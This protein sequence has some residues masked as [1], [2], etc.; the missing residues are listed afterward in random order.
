MREQ[1]VI[2]T[3]T[4]KRQQLSLATQVVRMILKIDDIRVPDEDEYKYPM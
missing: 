1:N 3:L 4:S 2:E